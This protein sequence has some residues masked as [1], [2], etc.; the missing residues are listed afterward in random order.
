MSIKR[1]F[2]ANVNGHEIGR[3]M[4]TVPGQVASK[5]VTQLVKHKKSGTKAVKF[6]L[7]ETTQGGAH[8]EY[9]YS[10]RRIKLKTPVVFTVKGVDITKHYK[11]EVKRIF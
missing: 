5:V 8:K 6:T 2:R 11:N 4:G 3:Y 9:Q 1:S 10:G 7:I